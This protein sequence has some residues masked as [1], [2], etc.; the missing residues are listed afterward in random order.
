MNDDKIRF[1]IHN[2]L[3][4]MER[5]CNNWHLNHNDGVVRGLLWALCGSDPGPGVTENS[6]RVL[7]LMGYHTKLHRGT[8]IWWTPDEQE[9]DAEA[10]NVIVAGRSALK[11]CF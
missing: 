7:Q 10:C 8:V 2:R 6:K 4:V 5:S 9:P 1:A 11:D 3:D